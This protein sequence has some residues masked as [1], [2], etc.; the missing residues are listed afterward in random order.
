MLKRREPIQ[1]RRE[2]TAHT[3]TDQIT[4]L[5]DRTN[6]LPWLEELMAHTHR[7]S[8]RVVL[9]FLGLGHL[10]EINQMYGP[11]VGDEVL[12]EVAV[13]LAKGVPEDWRVA[14]YAG[15]E[16]AVC[17]PGVA[18]SEACQR[19]AA[20][21][22][23]MLDAPLPIGQT[24]VVVTAFVGG[25][26]AEPGFG[27]PEQWLR[28]AHEALTEARR[29]GNRAIVVHDM[30]TR[31]RI[32]TII[33]EERI[34]SAFENEEFALVYQ[35]IVIPANGALVGFEALLRWIDPGTGT[36]LLAPD[37]FLPLLERTGLIAPV[38][39][40]VLENATRQVRSW[41]DLRP[42]EERLFVSVN[43]GGRQIAHP[44]FADSVAHAL[45]ASGLPP[46]LL[47]LDVT[48]EAIRFNRHSV[49]QVL[50][51]LKYIG[52]RLAL[53]DFGVGESSLAYLRELRLD[54]LRID[55]LFIEGLGS[56]PEDTAIVRH[57]VAL[58][59]DLGLLTLAEGVETQQ[60][61]ETLVEV[62]CALAQGFY[63]GRP[64]TAAELQDLLSPE[65]DASSA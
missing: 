19:M 33:D 35:P 12:R 41:N 16:F 6:L 53:D 47:T 14:R 60:Q 38:G 30:A 34:R 52:V 55:P 26:I 58:A 5:P 7:T 28:E 8:E 57:V 36:G 13:R 43:L 21:L 45:D 11:D 2:A 56:T 32:D 50:R 22:L 42:H 59:R 31:S 23:T 61:A 18:T 63:F 25:A 51:D 20:E 37:L 44:S 1:S 10:D 24:G 9:F 39:S 15:A 62:S 27:G 48:P 46:E 4:G 17:A 49:W 64:Q 29:E 54:L 40:W 3:G 65:G